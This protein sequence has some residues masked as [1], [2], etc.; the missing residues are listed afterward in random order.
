MSCSCVWSSRKPAIL[1][2]ETLAK[3]IDIQAADA[4]VFAYE[5]NAALLE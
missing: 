4:L 2:T 1:A 5:K 3:I